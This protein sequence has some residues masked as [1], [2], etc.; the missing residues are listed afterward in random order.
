MIKY[1]PR[2][3][4]NF[5]RTYYNSLLICLTL[6][7]IFRPYNDSITYL[8]IW[9]VLL[10][11]TL[12][13]ATF[14]CSRSHK[15]QIAQTALAIPT[16]TF[17]W[18]DIFF[19]HP[20]IFVI[21]TVFNIV[22]ISLATTT[23]IQHVL[24]KT[25]VTL[26]T[27]KGVICAYF[28]VAIAFAYVFWIIEYFEPNS[29]FISPEHKAFYYY[30]QYLSEML[31]FSFIT[32]LTIGYGDI[33]AVK[34]VGQT[35]VML[36]GLIGQFYVVILVARLVATYS[37]REQTKLQQKTHDSKGSIDIPKDSP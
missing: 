5:L 8:A 16:I 25:K 19:P 29:F 26:E 33:V 28:L 9:K 10:T 15:M 36:E 17:C 21:T 18:I 3:I 32:L 4:L 14:N 34:N 30:T 37:F 24:L 7:I 20:I 1:V 23:I 31:Y 35:A 2:L 27:L 6:L 22:F 11:G 12:L 13:A